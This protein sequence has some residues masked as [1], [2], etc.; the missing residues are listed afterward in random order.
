MARQVK[1]SVVDGN[2]EVEGRIIAA[3]D[4]VQEVVQT[5][6]TDGA[7]SWRFEKT[8]GTTQDVVVYG[9][10]TAGGAGIE[11]ITFDPSTGELV[12]TLTD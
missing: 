1:P 10:T 6:A 2:L 4:E 5:R 11:S 12:I 8:D 9:K 7:A 3:E